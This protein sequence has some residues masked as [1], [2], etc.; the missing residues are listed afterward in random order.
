MLD[1]TLLRRRLQRNRARAQEVR[2]RA[3][4]ACRQAAQA[5]QQAAISCQHARI[6]CLRRSMPEATGLTCA[7]T[8]MILMQRGLLNGTPAASPRARRRASRR[9]AT[10]GDSHD[11]GRLSGAVHR[12][13]QSAAHP[14][15]CPPHCLCRDRP[16][17]SLPVHLLCV[18]LQGYVAYGVLAPPGADV[19]RI[20]TCGG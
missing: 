2:R 20:L 3:Q 13:D 19:L 11:G 6:A 7:I 14:G 15:I 4:Q 8:A 5:Q 18:D 10:K 9:K 1:L 17:I 16:C 12:S